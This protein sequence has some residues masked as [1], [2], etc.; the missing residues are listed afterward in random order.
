V[1]VDRSDLEKT[2][3]EYKDRNFKIYLLDFEGKE[4]E[5]VELSENS[6]FVLGD[7]LGL[8]KEHFEIASKYSDEVVSLGNTMY[9]T[10]QCIFILNYFYDKRFG[11]KYWD[12]SNKFKVNF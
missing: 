12:T 9:F 6:L 11:C 2:M 5:N 10:S 8:E 7:F 4:I 3:K 1:Y